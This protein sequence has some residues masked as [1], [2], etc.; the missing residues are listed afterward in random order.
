[1]THKETN[2]HQSALKKIGVVGANYLNRIFLT[3][4]VLLPTP[5]V[6]KGVT[7][8][9]MA[10]E[11]TAGEV[12]CVEA[13]TARGSTKM[14]LA[15]PTAASTRVICTVRAVVPQIHAH[16]VRGTVAQVAMEMTVKGAWFVGQTTAEISPLQPPPGL[17]AANIRM[18]K[19]N[20]DHVPMILQQTSRSLLLTIIVIPMPTATTTFTRGGSGQ[21]RQQLV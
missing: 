9:K 13:T 21:F 2:T 1:M 20:R 17:T 6:I 7:A 4:F 12:W 14:L 3:S 11:G 16:L 5:V 10:Q 15:G 8:M 18:W 19:M